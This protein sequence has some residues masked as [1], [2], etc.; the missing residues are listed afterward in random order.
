[1]PVSETCSRI[2]S[3][4]RVGGITILPN[5]RDRPNIPEDGPRHSRASSAEPASLKA[6]QDRWRELRTFN[7]EEQWDHP[8]QN[9]RLTAWRHAVSLGTV[10]IHNQCH[11]GPELRNRGQKTHAARLNQAAYRS[12]CGRAWPAVA[13]FDDSPVV[14]HQSAAQGHKRQGKRGF[15]ASGTPTD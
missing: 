5:L 15:S 11:P 2:G 4:A 7:P 1:M 12:G 13:K 6:L 3:G 10:K 14:S 9:L 8:A